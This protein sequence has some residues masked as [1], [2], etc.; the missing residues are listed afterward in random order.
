SLCPVLQ[1][2]DRARDRVPDLNELGGVTAE[3][4]RVRALLVN[5]YLRR[6]PSCCYLDFQSG[7]SP[8]LILGDPLTH[9]PSVATAS[10]SGIL[11]SPIA[12]GPIA[13]GD[14]LRNHRME[15]FHSGLR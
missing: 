15:R 8:T 12:L 7:A 4:E 11:G 5:A 1:L 6:L 3:R 14:E 13:L 2:H 9:L 10:T